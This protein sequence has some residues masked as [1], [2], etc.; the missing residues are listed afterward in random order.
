MNNKLT[1][2]EIL[3]VPVNIND[4]LPTVTFNKL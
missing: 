1:K 3:Y 2:V 4:E